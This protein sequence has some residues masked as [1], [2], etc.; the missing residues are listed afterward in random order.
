MPYVEGKTL[1]FLKTIIKLSKACLISQP[2]LIYF[3]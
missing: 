2:N 1:L 3:L